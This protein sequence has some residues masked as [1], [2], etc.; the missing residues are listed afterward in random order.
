M[1]TPIVTGNSARTAT[2]EPSTNART[3]EAGRERTDMT[4]TG[5]VLVSRGSRT[6]TGRGDGLAVLIRVRCP[7]IISG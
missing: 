5:V 6:S 3:M 7:Q 4:E 2:D 1:S